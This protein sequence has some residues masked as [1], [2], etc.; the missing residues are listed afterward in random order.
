MILWSSLASSAESHAW[1][2]KHCCP[3]TKFDP[4]DAIAQCPICQW[5]RLILSPWYVVIPQRDFLDAWWQ[6]DYIMETA[7]ICSH[8]N[9]HLYLHMNLSSLLIILCQPHPHKLTKCLISARYSPQH[10][11]W[12]RNYFHSKRLQPW[13]HTHRII[14]HPEM[15]DLIKFRMAYWFY[16]FPRWPSGKESTCQYRRCKKH[17]FEPWVS[18]ILWGR[19]WQPTPVFLPEKFQ[20]QRAWWT[21][22][23]GATKGTTW[24]STHT[25]W[26]YNSIGWK[27][28]LKRWHFVSSDAMH[29]L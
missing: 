7:E 2:Q 16:G 5:H 20:G 10:F 4:A 11:F 9:R 19:K 8:W 25:H 27:T 15:A 22:V 18:K 1:A 24:L 14:Y 28:T 23:H 17:R 3:L 26:F 6:L 13:A 29:A 21:I 12:G